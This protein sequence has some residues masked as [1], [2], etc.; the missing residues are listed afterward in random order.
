MYICVCVCVHLFIIIVTNNNYYML[1]STFSLSLSKPEAIPESLKNML[2]V[3]VTQGVLYVGTS[4][5]TQ[6]EV[7]NELCQ[8][9]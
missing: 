1:L 6:E 7:S 2:L 9:M 8:L 3:M 4:P 5:P